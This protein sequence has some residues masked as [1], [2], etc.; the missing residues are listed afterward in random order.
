MYLLKP[1]D[2][3][4]N[5]HVQKHLVRPHRSASISLRYPSSFSSQPRDV[6]EIVYQGHLHELREAN[7]LPPDS[8]REYVDRSLGQ[9]QFLTMLSD[10]LLDQQVA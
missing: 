7:C 4:L 1:I 2:R 10:G 3:L 6:L 8:L 5:R 9:P